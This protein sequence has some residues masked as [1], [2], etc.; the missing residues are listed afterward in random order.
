MLWLCWANVSRHY[1]TGHGLITAVYT[2]DLTSGA[3]GGCICAKV[4]GWYMWAAGGVWDV[5]S[6]WTKVGV[7]A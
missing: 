7:W 2:N 3:I 5:V 6:V 4:S 1:T